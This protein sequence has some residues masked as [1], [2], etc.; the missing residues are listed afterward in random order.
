MHCMAGA[1][2]LEPA[3]RIPAPW[4]VSRCGPQRLGR[5]ALRRRARESPRAGA[6][7]GAGHGLPADMEQRTGGRR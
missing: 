2:P 4:K 6:R 3:T 5:D 7:P 1:L